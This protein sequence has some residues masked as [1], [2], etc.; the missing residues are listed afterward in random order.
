MQIAGEVKDN[1]HW[2]IAYYINTQ[3]VNDASNGDVVAVIWQRLEIFQSTITA[4]R[5]V[6]QQEVIKFGR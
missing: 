1:M 6:L 5:D 3:C 4:A 2:D